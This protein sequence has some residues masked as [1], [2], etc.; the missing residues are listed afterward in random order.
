MAHFLISYNSSD[1]TSYTSRDKEWAYWIDAQLKALG[2]DTFLDW[3]I[4]TLGPRRQESSR[5]IAW[6]KQHQDVADY[7]LCVVSHSYLSLFE[8]NSELRWFVHQQRSLFVVVEP[9]ELPRLSVYI[10]SCELFGI[11]DLAA[12]HR[13][14]EFIEKHVK[15]FEPANASPMRTED[16]PPIQALMRRRL[17]QQPLINKDV[18]QERA[19]EI[20]VIEGRYTHRADRLREQADQAE[21]RRSEDRRSPPSRPLSRLEEREREIEARL[22]YEQEHAR[23]IE[24]RRYEQERLREQVDQA[25]ARRSEDRRSR[26]PSRPLS[27]WYRSRGWVPWLLVTLGTAAYIWR[28]ELMQ[29]AHSIF[30]LL[31]LAAATM[32]PMIVQER[33]EESTD[34]VD[35]SA[36][37]PLSGCAGENVLVQIFL[38]ALEERLA[39][40]VLA[41][42][43]D[44]ETRERGLTTLAVPVQRGQR[45]DVVL[46]AA[47]TEVDESKQSLI[48]RGE[49]RSCQFVLGLPAELAG[50]TCQIKARMLV[51]SVPVGTL[52]FTLEVTGVAAA[53]GLEMVG[54]VAR[55][56]REA[57]LSHSHEDRVK[58]FT[59]VQLLDKL[60]IKYFQ[61]I[62]SIRAMDDWE[63]RL[64]EA[65]D[66]CDLFL[67]FWTKSAAHSEWVE[68]EARYALACQA[69]REEP[70]I[71]PLFLEA[72]APKVPDWLKSR[73]F[74][75]LIRLAM[76]GADAERQSGRGTAV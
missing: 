2:Q 58:V 10:P 55:R 47:G 74:D 57:F 48:W 66:H 75:S 38:H 29:A 52:R 42:E 32:P 56:Y 8:R 69:A 54:E 36:F 51:D 41:R 5:E 24:A 63:Q 61:D 16:E 50:H 43:A 11:S 45:I 30:K 70:D 68:R 59:F 7:L 26:P 23:E 60:G 34:V 12:R 17:E 62:A 40:A 3:E 35:A 67:L 22:R 25:E 6:I 21:A 39:A 76:R 64:H 65:I 1:L 19:R 18:T 72:E 37:A 33:G 71:W 27:R 13:F 44:A 73:Q 31:G 53:S 9:C 49:P 46:E 28:H 4:D 20:G 14:R 15:R